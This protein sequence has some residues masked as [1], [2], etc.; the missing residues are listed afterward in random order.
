MGRSKRLTALAVTR[1][2]AARARGMFAD[3]DN[4]YLQTRTTG[5]SWIFGFA[6]GGRERF[7]GLGP[8][9][10]VSLKEA[11]NLA[12]EARRLLRSGTNPLAEKRAAKAAARTPTFRVFAQA[13]I[14]GHKAG[15]SAGHAEQTARALANHVYPVIGD[16]RI[17]QIDTDAVMRVLRGLWDERTVTGDRVRG[18]IEAVLAGAAA[19]GLRTGPNPAAWRNH[20]DKLLPRPGKVKPV[21]HLAA[22]DYSEVPGLTAELRAQPGIAASALRFC[23]LTASRSGET[24]HATW[25]E[26]DL[27][28]RVW[29]IPAE[30]MKA[31]KQHRVPLS[32]AAVEILEA[33]AAIRS[34]DY[35]FPGRRGGEPLSPPV[36]R[37]VLKRAGHDDVV[38]HGFRSAF[39]DW[40]GDQGFPREIAEAALAHAVGNSV[41]QAYRRGDALERRRALMSAWASYCDRSAGRSV[42]SFARV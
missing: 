7:M 36:L 15:W 1:A 3:G 35:V 25:S 13:H 27:E 29:T 9:P 39:R 31:R 14:E 23:I 32:P 42:V 10:E 24:L 28:Q 41:E 20:L 19:N 30:R 21:V 12:S 17:D 5:A 11:R 4:L 16:M 2:C 34:G 38:P 40:A 33:M 6:F 18:I 22:M 8:A 26:F 37:L